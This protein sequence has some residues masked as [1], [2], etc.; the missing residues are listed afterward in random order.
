MTI[1]SAPRFTRDG[2]ALGAVVLPMRKDDAQRLQR[3]QSTLR[4]GA[5]VKYATVPN[6]A[7]GT[8]TTTTTTTPAISNTV[9]QFGS[10]STTLV[11]KP[12]SHEVPSV[13][14]VVVDV[15][16][17]IQ[18]V[19]DASADLSK[20]GGAA[21]KSTP[22]LNN[23]RRLSKDLAAKMKLRSG[24]VRATMAVIQE[25]VPDPVLTEKLAVE[26]VVDEKDQ[27]GPHPRPSGIPSKRTKSFWGYIIGSSR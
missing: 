20:P 25:K 1:E 8:T 27:S 18:A 7:T 10:S 3:Q 5:H 13:R 12:S 6:P 14:V 15:D 24:Q 4:S 17:T 21:R 11:E 9:N 19:V 16:G 22:A 23:V 26:L 2:I